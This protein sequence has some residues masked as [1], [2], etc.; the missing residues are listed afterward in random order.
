MEV[1]TIDE[2]REAVVREVRDKDKKELDYHV[3]DTMGRSVGEDEVGGDGDQN[4]YEEERSRDHYMPSV[5]LIDAYP[6]EATSKASKLVASMKEAAC[7]RHPVRQQRLDVTTS[8]H[9]YDDA[10]SHHL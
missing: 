9:F 6:P 2:C 7:V 8:G 3:V 1:I 4:T 5:R 10:S